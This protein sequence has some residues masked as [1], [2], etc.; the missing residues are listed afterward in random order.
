MLIEPYKSVGNLLFTDNRQQIREKL[1]ESFISGVKG[2]TD[3]Y[4]Y[5]E[6]SGLFV[7]Y[8]KNDSVNAFEFFDSKPLFNS[9]NLVA[10]YYIPLL[11]LFKELD[12]KLIID[13]NSFTSNKYGIGINTN[14]DPE[15]NSALSE[16]VIIFKKGYYDSL[17]NGS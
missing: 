16:A 15:S 11:I 4:D 9:V 2:V 14:D 7:Y 10:V 1:N 3:Y 12:P 8:D 6:S 17:P 13:Y 5:F